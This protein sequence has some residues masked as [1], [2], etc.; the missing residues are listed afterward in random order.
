MFMSRGLQ[1]N[2]K[3]I[4]LVSLDYPK[5]I[6]YNT[7]NKTFTTGENDYGYWRKN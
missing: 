2:I 5:Q 1:E 7:K 4:Y 6:C 3:Q